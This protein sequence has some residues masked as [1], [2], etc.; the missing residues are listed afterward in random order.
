MSSGSAFF[1]QKIDVMNIIEVTDPQRPDFLNNR[2]PESHKGTYG[3]ALLVAGS[4]GKM[5]AAVLAARACLRMGAGLLT[6]HVPRKGV[7]I[8][9]VAVPEAMVSIDEDEERWSHLFTVEELA[10]YDAVAVGPGLGTKSSEALL[11][12]LKASGEKPLVV[13]ADGLNMLA[14][15]RETMFPLLSQRKAATVLT[16]H[17]KEFERLFGRY[18]DAEQRMEAQLEMAKRLGAV[19]LYKGHRTHIAGTNGAM[20]VNTT[21]NA[22]MS[23]AGSGDVLTGII[24]GILSQNKDN[25]LNAEECACMGVWLHGKSA[26]IAVQKQSQCSLVASDMI[27]FLRLATFDCE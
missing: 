25:Q 21:G 23:T 10:K 20:Y 15:N 16:P 24:L 3:H 19:I 11:A 26:D 1:D 7:D 18:D 22:G 13:D 8:M 4:Y 5:G 6:V 17:A 12:L 27:N 2:A 14:M 9:Q